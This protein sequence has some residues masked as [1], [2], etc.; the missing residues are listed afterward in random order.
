M[1]AI[2]LKNEFISTCNLPVAT[3]KTNKLYYLHICKNELEDIFI[4][5]ENI[6][7]CMTG[8]PWER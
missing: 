7:Q 3:K 8:Y 1:P 2:F 4:T 6:T 5:Q